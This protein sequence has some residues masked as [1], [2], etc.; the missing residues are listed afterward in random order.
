MAGKK[1]KGK[2]KDKKAGK[3]KKPDFL[4]V[5]KDGN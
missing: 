4:D 3:G 1:G 2:S 5:D